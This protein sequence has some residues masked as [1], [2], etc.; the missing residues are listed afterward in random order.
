MTFE[1]WQ[2]AEDKRRWKIVRRDTMENVPG[3]IIT[4]NE[5]SGECCV[6]IGGETK[7]LS[8]GWRGLK[9]VPR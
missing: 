3:N 9:L 1:S 6:E 2:S 4:A 7:T 5:D 8:F